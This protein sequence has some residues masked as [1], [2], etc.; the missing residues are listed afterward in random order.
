MQDLDT[1]APTLGDDFVLNSVLDNVSFVTLLR[2]TVGGALVIKALYDTSIKEWENAF[3]ANTQEHLVKG[4]FTS[5][6]K[7]DFIRV[8]IAKLVAQYM[9]SVG[10]R[11]TAWTKNTISGDNTTN[12]AIANRIAATEYEGNDPLFTLVVTRLMG[13]DDKLVE[14]AIESNYTRKAVLLVEYLAA[15]LELTDGEIDVGLLYPNVID[16][17][18]TKLKENSFTAE[19]FTSFLMSVTDFS[20]KTD[21]P[22]DPLDLLA[23]FATRD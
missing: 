2:D 7:S 12:V 1:T 11:V 22:G 16:V 10:V 6:K 4:V 21:A 13:F 20:S 14:Y 23:R 5:T 17:V 9:K 19:Y 18:E 8:Y 3:D 15:K